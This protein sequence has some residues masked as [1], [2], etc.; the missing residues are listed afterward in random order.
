[1]LF[2][3]VDDQHAHISGCVSENRLEARD[4]LVRSVVD[5]DDDDGHG[6]SHFFGQASAHAVEDVPAES[7]TQK[8][9]HRHEEESGEGR[10]P[11]VIQQIAVRRYESSHWVELQ[12]TLGPRGCAGL[13]QLG[14][15]DDGRQEEPHLDEDRPEVGEVAEEIGRAHV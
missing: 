5:G 10:T 15:V 9:S 4:R 3:S 2:R 8:R 12:N 11:C 1:M 13:E 7:K 14:S 6:V